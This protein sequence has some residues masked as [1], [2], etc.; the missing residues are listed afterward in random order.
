MRSYVLELKLIIGSLYNNFP[1]ELEEMQCVLEEKV[2]S[3][4]AI[5]EFEGS[6]K[7]SYLIS[8]F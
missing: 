3:K 4:E 2:I 5:K 6:E 7:K 1:S 8:E